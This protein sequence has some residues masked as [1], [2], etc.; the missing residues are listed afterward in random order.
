MIEDLI[1]RAERLRQEVS[2][3]AQ[4]EADPLRSWAEVEEAFY[5]NSEAYLRKTHREWYRGR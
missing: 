3:H 4:R 1:G 5:V 2:R